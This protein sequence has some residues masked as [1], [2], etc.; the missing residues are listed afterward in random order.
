MSEKNMKMV[1]VT[2]LDL[3]KGSMQSLQSPDLYQVTLENGSVVIIQKAQAI[4]VM[5]VKIIAE[6]TIYSRVGEY[7]AFGAEGQLSRLVGSTGIRPALGNAPI[8]QDELDLALHLKAEMQ[9]VEMMKSFQQGQQGRTVAKSSP[10]PSLLLLGPLF[11]TAF[12]L[13]RI[14]ALDF[15]VGTEDISG[16]VDQYAQHFLKSELANI[17][18]CF[19]VRLVPLDTTGDGNCLA[20]AISRSLMGSEVLFYTLR[21]QLHRELLSNRE[22]YLAAAGSE[23]VFAKVLAES[24]KIYPTGRGEYLSWIHVLGFAN[25]LRRPIFLMTNSRQSDVSIENIAL[26]AEQEPG[27][28]LPTRFTP[29]QCRSPDGSVPG[30]LCIAWQGNS[31]QGRH[32]VA[33]V[34]HQQTTDLFQDALDTDCEGALNTD[35]SAHF[36]FPLKKF[37]ATQISDAHEEIVPEGKKATDRLTFKYLEKAFTSRPLEEAASQPGTKFV[38]GLLPAQEYEHFQTELTKGAVV[39]TVETGTLKPPL[40]TL[41]SLAKKYPRI[42]HALHLQLERDTAGQARCLRGL[43]QCLEEVLEDIILAKPVRF[44]VT[45]ELQ[46]AGVLI[47]AG[48]ARVMTGGVCGGR[49]FLRAVGFEEDEQAISTA[50]PLKKDDLGITSRDSWNKFFNP[51]HT[52]TN[53]ARGKQLEE[54]LK[55]GGA[56]SGTFKHIQGLAYGAEGSLAFVCD[57]LKAGFKHED[58]DIT[59]LQVGDQAFQGL[60]GLLEAAARCKRKLTA[61]RFILI[62]LALLSSTAKAWVSSGKTRASKLINGLLVQA[63]MYQE[64]LRT[65]NPKTDQMEMINVPPLLW[66]LT[67]LIH[68]DSQGAGEGGRSNL[69]V[70]VLAAYDQILGVIEGVVECVASID[71][72]IRQDLPSRLLDAASTVAAVLPKYSDALTKRQEWR[73]AK[74]LLKIVRVGTGRLEG[75]KQPSQGP[76]AACHSSAPTKTPKCKGTIC[77]AKQR[78]TEADEFDAQAVKWCLGENGLGIS[79]LLQ[80]DFQSITVPP[81]VSRVLSALA[82]AVDDTKR[83]F[84]GLSDGRQS[85]HTTRVKGLCEQLARRGSAAPNVYMLVHKDEE[86]LRGA[87]AIVCGMIDRSAVSGTREGGGSGGG[88]GGGGSGG[89][90]S[91]GESRRCIPIAGDEDQRVFMCGTREAPFYFR[92]LHTSKMNCQRSGMIAGGISAPPLARTESARDR[93]SIRHFWQVARSYAN[94]GAQGWRL[95]FGSDPTPFQSECRQTLQAAFD[96]YVPTARGQF[97]EAM[98][99]DITPKSQRQSFAHPPLTVLPEAP[100]ETFLS[101]VQ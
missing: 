33:V 21:H 7:L 18:K 76:C 58:G 41:K 24:N 79:L 34:R 45:K 95:G 101:Q 40:V 63:T 74:L 72:S 67:N 23:A 80:H 88:S 51:A 62:Q 59:N 31:L 20:H 97:E 36:Y 46:D 8:T 43:R 82:P 5:R 75:R 6:I 17:E 1:S 99:H 22:Y 38:V 52:K 86:T 12:D 37:T 13:S 25:L 84:E 39:Y 90:G 14:N 66:C 4:M 30:P 50:R 78:H 26:L 47:D 70:Q 91:G 55:E 28:Y 10:L 71:T 77:D 65:L 93:E 69:R 48:D 56:S 85:S 3:C 87:L 32:Y 19:H 68:A 94:K 16:F 81:I 64:R 42:I 54:L 29:E 44:M 92:Q 11:S 57:R 60:V 49:E 89:G 2:V 35:V 53:G 9:L 83:V 73:L 100:H 98:R 61:P 27:L 96:E 15:V